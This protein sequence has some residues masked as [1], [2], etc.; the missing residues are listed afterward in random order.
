MHLWIKLGLQNQVKPCE[1]F[2]VSPT[3]EWADHPITGYETNHFWWDLEEPKPATELIWKELK[4]NQLCSAMKFRYTV[5]QFD[6]RTEAVLYWAQLAYPTKKLSATEDDYS[7]KLK[8]NARDK[9]LVAH[10]ED[11]T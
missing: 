7:Q 6:T 2:A 11:T 8:K 3:Q 9:N 10:P 4:A 1:P 5:M